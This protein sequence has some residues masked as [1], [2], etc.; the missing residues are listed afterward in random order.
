MSSNLSQKVTS[1]LIWTFGERILAQI[2]SFVV[3]IVL[4]RFLLPEEYGI[5]TLVMVFI[6]LAN[7]FVSNG[8]GESLVQKQDS[9]ETDFSTIFWCSFG[10][11]I[12]L[13]TLLFITTPLI[14]DYYENKEM[15]WVLRVLALKL[16]I[17]SIST[18][19]HA[20]VSKHMIFKK[21]FF[22]TL[23]GTVVSGIVGIILAINGY[24]PWALVSQYLINT[25]IDTLVLFVT[26]EWR[27]R[28]IFSK[29]SAK[30]LIG[31]SWKITAA[32]FINT[33]YGE[34]RALI[35]GKKYSSADLAYYNKGSQ[36]PSLVITNINTAISTVVFP[37]MSSVNNNIDRLKQLTRRFMQMTSYVITPIIIGMIV[38]AKPMVQILLTDK[39]LPSVPFVQILCLYWLLQPMQT[40][41]WQSIKA[42][43]R[44]DLCFKLEIVKKTIGIVLI[45]LT[46]NI[47]TMALAWS[48]VVFAFVSMLINMVPNI[49]LINYPIKEQLWDLKSGFVLSIIMGIVV[50][51]IQF[52]P[53]NPILVL[54]LQVIF[55]AVLYIALSELFHVEAFIMLKG[56]VKS[57]FQRGGKKP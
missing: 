2:T 40:A 26:V 21:F 3:S 44:S 39:W 50:Y 29:Q 6:T 18:I 10:F 19:Q 24:G 22:S 16:P 47:G 8:F 49:K 12:I 36:F 32:S 34:L 15:V 56:I 23:G 5:V 4:A 33:A 37:A 48:S 30:Q 11:S 25:T 54:I 42:V 55:G 53:L 27:P 45:L 7:V 38:V 52:L 41:N 43:G 9:D 1:G 35:I 13:Y 46:M 31:F 20:Y 14:A 17:S 51:I 57:L 28:F